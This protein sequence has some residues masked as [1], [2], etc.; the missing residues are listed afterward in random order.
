M[1]KIIII[2]LLFLCSFPV[3][4]QKTQEEQKVYAAREYVKAFV[5]KFEKQG[6]PDLDNYNQNVKPA[7]ERI[8]NI[9]DLITLL[10]TNNLKSTGK[11]VEQVKEINYSNAE[12]LRINSFRNTDLTAT[13]DKIVEKLSAKI[14]PT[15]DEDKKVDPP[16][17]GTEEEAKK[18]EIDWLSI[19]AII[20]A[21]AAIFI[22]IF[23]KRGKACERENIINIVLKSERI[24]EK[25]KL[26]IEKDNNSVEL[27]INEATINRI[28]DLVK[29]K[30]LECIKLEEEDKEVKIWE[31]IR[32]I[33][34]RLDKKD[35]GGIGDP[36]ILYFKTKNNKV[37]YQ[38]SKTQSDALFKVNIKNSSFEY[39]GG[40]LS[41][42]LLSDVCE[43][44]NNPYKIATIYKIITKTPGKVF[45][46]AEGNWEVLTPA[47][48]EFL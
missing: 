22:A 14:A 3:F 6:T 15:Q 29:S 4:A 2:A 40:A 13:A 27:E 34:E 41:P 38:E 1:Q 28:V 16:E 26:L 9:D 42:D 32:K 30:V 36:N 33:W 47:K 5:P 31:E 19:I 35:R 11:L 48:I 45:K 20:A 24:E 18:T 12:S 44:I 39:C 10:N 46:N 23:K 37:F 8:N 43:F 17:E 7:L 25:I 21:I